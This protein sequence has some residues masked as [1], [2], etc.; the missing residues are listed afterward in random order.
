MSGTI[1]GSIPLNAS[2]LVISGKVFVNAG[3]AGPGT[4]ITSGMNTLRTGTELIGNGIWINQ[5]TLDF[6][7]DG[8]GPEGMTNAASGLI[9]FTAGASIFGELVNDGTLDVSGNASLGGLTG[10]GTVVISSGTLALGP[11]DL[12]GPVE[13]AG[14]LKI[15]SSATFEPGFSH[16]GLLEI[17]TG[18]AGIALKGTTTTLNGVVLMSG[19]SI[20]GP[21]TLVTTG[22]VTALGVGLIAGAIWSNTGT[23]DLASGQMSGEGFINQAGGMLDLTGNLNPFTGGLVTNLGTLING[24]T[25]TTVVQAAVHDQGTII[26][27][28]GTLQF[29]GG[30]TFGGTLEGTGEISFANGL[31]NTLVAGATV[32]TTGFDVTGGTLFDYGT[33]TVGAVKVA[34]VLQLEGGSISVSGSLTINGDKELYGFGR[35]D[36]PIVNNGLIYAHG[37]ALVVEGSI[38]GGGS[39]QIDSRSTLELGAAAGQGHQVINFGQGGFSDGTLVLDAPMTFGGTLIGMT[40]GDSIILRNTGSAS[41]NL[42]ISATIGTLAGTQTLQIYEDTD[43]SYPNAAKSVPALKLINIPLPSPTINA[44]PPAQGFFKVSQSG[45]DTVLTLTAGNPVDL[46]V[47]GPSARSVFGANGNG[48]KVGIISG[49]ILEAQAMAEVV[50]AIAPIANVDNLTVIQTMGNIGANETQL[51]NAIMQL[52]SLGC[53]IIVDDLGI[54]GETT[55]SPVTREIDS[56]VNSGVVYITAAGQ[57]DPDANGN[58]PPAHPLIS[59]HEA[60][61]NALAVAAMNVLATPGSLTSVGGYLQPQTEAHGFIQAP[62]EANLVTGPDGGPGPGGFSATKLQGVFFGSS[63]AA[64]AVAGVAALMLNANPALKTKPLL[65]DKLLEQSAVHFVDN[66]PGLDPSEPDAGE[67]LGLVQ[68]YGAVALAKSLCFC[69]GARIATPTGT[70][71]VEDLK[72]GDQVITT[73]GGLRR[74]VWIGHGKVLATRGRR[75]AA[76]PVIVRKGALAGNVPDADLRVTKGHSLYLDGVLIPVEFLVNH[77]TILWDDHAQVVSVYHI[78]LDA[79][80]VLLANGAPAESYRDDGNRWLFQN[81]NSGWDQPPKPPCAPVLTGGPVV[82]AVWR[83]LLERAGPR[84]GLP[85]TTDPDLHLLV[86]GVPKKPTAGLDDWAAFRLSEPPQAVRIAS[87]AGIPQELGLTRDPRALGVPVREIVVRHGSTVRMAAADDAVLT[88]GFHDFEPDNGIRWTDGDASLPRTLLAGLGG[89]VEI[90]LRLGGRTAYVDDVP[91][92]RAA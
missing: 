88:E 11:S 78:E 37:G 91:G 69:P 72:V 35:V 73:F 27:D 83:R 6:L 17:L 31:G 28:G 65:V 19:S 61:P 9:D 34:G 60:D 46:A 49:T 15:G 84:P 63:A 66:S 82:D 89:P 85:T 1:T 10:A 25:A 45:A 59:G 79:H 24:E 51:A 62:G 44:L 47:N 70:V 87:R 20:D 81:A 33:A 38:S 8:V 64:P 86:D 42:V 52:Q 4:L 55:D 75:S 2:T 74:I 5:G 57:T 39:V 92:R 80:D 14:V 53:N 21:G 36:G 43:T 22:T 77:R 13:G 26:D 29:D 16:T 58:W 3:F 76:T 41:G 48:V 18:S 50:N 32:T 23:V 71:R 54:A 56:V 12:D 68:A 7:S 30:G 90:I 67:G 40:D